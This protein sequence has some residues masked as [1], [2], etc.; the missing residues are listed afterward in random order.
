LQMQFHVRTVE[1]A[2]TITHMKSH[3]LFCKK[4]R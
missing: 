2:D 3:L 1:T 4:K